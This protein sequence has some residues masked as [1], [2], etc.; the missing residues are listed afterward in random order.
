M[1]F[2]AAFL[3]ASCGPTAAWANPKG[4][5]PL[6]TMTM[7]EIMQA[8]AAGTGCAWLGGEGRTLRVAMKEDRG[9]VKR[10]GRVI[11][12]VPAAG[13]KE[14]FPYTYHRWRGEGM[15]IAIEDSGR[16]VGQGTEHLETTAKLTLTENGR[17]R[18]WQ[19][20]LSCGS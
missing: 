18:S 20:R 1:R 14:V 11:R 2:A 13:A 3:L 6:Q 8:R 17:S 10:A 7:D 5:L 16:L 15:E 12:L 19:G 4:D 9:A